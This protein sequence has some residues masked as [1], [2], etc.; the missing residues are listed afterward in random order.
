VPTDPGAFANTKAPIPG[1]YAANDNRV[2]AALE[3]AKAELAKNNVPCE[4]HCFERAGHGFLRQQNGS[5]QAPANGKA[6]EQ[7]RPLML[8]FIRKHTR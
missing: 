3:L 5:A 2:N 4:Q 8:E 1:L 6:S 7:A